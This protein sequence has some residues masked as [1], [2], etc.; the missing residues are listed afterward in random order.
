MLPEDLPCCLGISPEN[1]RREVPT[2]SKE[3]PDGPGKSRRD[4]PCP[5]SGT[6][7]PLHISARAE[8]E[9]RYRLRGW[10]GDGVFEM[11]PT[12]SISPSQARAPRR[13]DNPVEQ[14][15]EIR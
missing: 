14:K 6:P 1:F 9:A 10:E 4:W 12:I 13:R 8:E 2:H 11:H 5:D 3:M 15:G 7:T